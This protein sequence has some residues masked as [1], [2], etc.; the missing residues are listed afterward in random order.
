MNNPEFIYDVTNDLRNDQNN[1][2]MIN[3][4][5]A[6]QTIKY[7]TAQESMSIEDILAEYDNDIYACAN[8]MNSFN[9]VNKTT[10]EFSTDGITIYTLTIVYDNDNESEYEDL[11]NIALFDTSNEFTISVSEQS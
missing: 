6:Y 8:D 7:L 9:I 10:V 4:F 5:L 1:Q 11:N 2:N 3:A